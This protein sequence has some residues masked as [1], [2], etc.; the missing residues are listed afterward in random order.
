[1]GLLSE[2]VTNNVHKKR[3]VGIDGWEGLLFEV[4][5]YGQ[6]MT[7]FL[8]SVSEESVGCEV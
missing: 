1:M 3:I 8:L 2:L 5:E 7:E 6:G 4:G